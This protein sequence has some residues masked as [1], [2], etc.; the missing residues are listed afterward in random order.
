MGLV[1]Q[2][3]ETAGK[4]HNEDQTAGGAGRVA[5]GAQIAQHAQEMQLKREELERKKGELEGAKYEKAI[6]AIQKGHTLQGQ[7]K[8]NYYNKVLPTYMGALGVADAFPPETLQF[9]TS[10]PE[11]MARLNTIVDDV[12]NGKRSIQDARGLMTDLVSFMDVPPSYEEAKKL[13]EDFIEADK[14]RI[15]ANAQRD[16]LMATNSRFQQG[17]SQA[18]DFQT[19]GNKEQLTKTRLQYGLQG[20]EN[21]LSEIDKIVPGG[22]ENWDKTPIKGV[23]GKDAK[24]PIK[25]LDAE[26]RK[27]RQI[28]QGLANQLLRMRSGGAVTPEESTRLL[29]EI[30]MD[31]AVGEGGGWTTVFKGTNSSESFVN[32]IR[33]VK[34]TTDRVNGELRNTFG[35]E[36]YDSVVG[37]PVQTRAKQPAK[38]EV[39]DAQLA[40][41]KSLIEQ[42]P[43]ES[44]KVVKALA[45]K[46]GI[47]EAEA[48]K[49]LGVK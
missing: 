47:T 24:L 49:K 14:T 33:N 38:Q 9:V 40:P 20:I 46:L 25:Q 15:G 10:A 29:S 4:T 12:R 19:Q 44:A 48:K 45:G 41:F 32:G 3:I 6:E 17:Q 26:G 35:S 21:S 43:K 39:G 13:E 8:N 37:R 23:S 18:R 5:A 1:D 2:L 27:N 22:L 7:A 28:A 36:T 16:A 30:G 34:K 42:H 11:N 31:L